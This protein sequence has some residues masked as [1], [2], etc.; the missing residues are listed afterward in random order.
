M[1]KTN[2]KDKW[3]RQSLERDN[4][5]ETKLKENSSWQK[6]TSLLSKQFIESLIILIALCYLWVSFL[7]FATHYL[8]L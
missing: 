1:D 4:R 2:G 6:I 5:E 8:V 3:K 7:M